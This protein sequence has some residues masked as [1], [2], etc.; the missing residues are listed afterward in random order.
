M[1][2]IYRRILY[3][4]LFTA[5]NSHTSRRIFIFI[6]I[7]DIDNQYCHIVVRIY[8]SSKICRLFYYFICQYFWRQRAVFYQ[9][10]LKPVGSI[11]LFFNVFCL[12]NTVRIKYNSISIFNF[13]L[14]S[15]KTI[16]FLESNNKRI[17]F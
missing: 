9:R 11:Q 12:R 4:F 3:I 7:F 2:H 16:Y 10:R 15:C 13:Y 14:I 17:C 1:Q 6:V 5:K 8:S